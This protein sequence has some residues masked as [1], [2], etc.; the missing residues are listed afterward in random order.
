MPRY[1]LETLPS[2]AQYFYP[3]FGQAREE[4]REGDV[5]PLRIGAPVAEDAAARWGL[6][7][8]PCPP[9]VRDWFPASPDTLCFTHAGQAA[10]DSLWFTA[11]HKGRVT[12][13]TIVTQVPFGI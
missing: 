2:F 5:G 11:I 7:K 6:R 9:G 1:L 12:S 3:P 4:Y 8:E 13:V 10:H